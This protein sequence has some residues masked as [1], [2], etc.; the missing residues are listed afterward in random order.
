MILCTVCASPDKELLCWWTNEHFHTKPFLD[1]IHMAKE[2]GVFTVCG[3][4]CAHRIYERYL[5]HLRIAA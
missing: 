3:P 2:Q 4:Q 5:E 1:D